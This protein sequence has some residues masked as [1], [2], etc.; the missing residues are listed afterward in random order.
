MRLLVPF[1]F[2]CVLSS[3]VRA[4]LCDQA[5]MYV[6]KYALCVCTCVCACWEYKLILARG[7]TWGMALQEPHLSWAAAFSHSKF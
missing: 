1:V 7:W 4:D 6:Q 3:S 2:A 5:C